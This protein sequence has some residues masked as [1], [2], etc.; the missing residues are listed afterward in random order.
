M[1]RDLS[2]IE[3]VVDPKEAAEHAGLTSVSD[4]KPGIRRRRASKGFTYSGTAGSA[5]RVLWP[6]P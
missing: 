1:A 4:D 5:R 3:A 6:T 2:P